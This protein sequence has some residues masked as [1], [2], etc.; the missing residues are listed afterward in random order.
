VCRREC[1]RNAGALVGHAPSAAK[2]VDLLLLR[3]QST[4]AA[5]FSK[6]AMVERSGSAQ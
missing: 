2:S 4:A 6:W 5:L 1:G 3:R